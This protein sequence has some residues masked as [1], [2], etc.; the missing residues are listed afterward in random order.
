MPTSTH[1]QAS[2]DEPHLQT[3]RQSSR[4]ESSGLGSGDPRTTPRGEVWRKRSRGAVLLAS[5]LV[6]LVVLSLVGGRLWL[7]HAATSSLPKLDG[8]VALPGLSAPVLVRRDRLGTP[9]IQAAT[10]DD[11]VLAQGFVTATDRLFQ[12]DLLR[13][14]AA[15]ELAEIFGQR[16]VEHDRTERILSLDV[17][18]TRAVAALPADQLRQL[19]RYAEGVNAAMEQAHDHLPIEFRVLRYRPRPW[20]PRDTLLVSLSMYQ[21]LSTSFPTRLGREAVTAKLTPEMAADLYPTGSWRDHPAGQ[22]PVDLSAPGPEMEEIPLDESQVKL[23]RPG[24][25]NERPG[26]PNEGPERPSGPERRAPTFAS[27]A[28]LL[29]LR[30]LLSPEAVCDGC[31]KG[32]NNWVVS[33]A[34]TATGAPLLSNDMHLSLS[35]PDLWY[36]ADL[37]APTPAGEMHVAGVSLPGTPFIIVGHNAHISWGFTNL[38]AEVQDVALEHLRGGGAG[39]E[40]QTADGW[41]PVLH[42]QERIGVRG[43]RDITV[44]VRSTAHDGMETPLISD[45]YPSEGRPISLRWTVYD[46]TTPTSPFLAVN[47][48][49]NWEQFTEAFARFGGP[50]QNVVYADDGGHI[51]Y[52]AAGR[53]PIRGSV[54]SPSA[55]SPTTVDALDPAQIWVGYIP[56]GDL[57]KAF[58]P[59][60][61][62]LATANARVTPDGYPFPITLDWPDPYRNERIWKL[63]SG[64]SGLSVGDMLKIE[65]DVYSDLDL[66]IA[67]RLVYAIDHTAKPVSGR[68]REAADLLRSWNGEVAAGEAAPA[69]VVAT[70]SALWQMVLTP[71]LGD[72]ATLYTWGEKAFAQEAMVLHGP[73]RWLPP[74]YSDWNDLLAGAVEKGMADA[75]APKRLAAW[76]YGEDHPL[77][78]EHPVFSQSALLS[79]LLGVPTGE[80]ATHLSGDASTVKQIHPGGKSPGSALGPSERFTAD[81]ADLDRSTL[82]LTLGESGNPVSPWYM[83]QW[84]MWYG[85]RTADLPFSEGAVASATTHR[86]LLLPR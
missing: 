47:L 7:R 77:R 82:N 54:T 32:S 24:S 69:I 64:R 1:Q 18:A 26:S 42:R 40:F 29:S 53:I 76:R 39:A 70:R 3:R 63:L 71:K 48:A 84:P 20:T 56:F 80:V 60:R 14:H 35:A 46:P 83:D 4:A 15:G 50:S 52:H 12:M 55:L 25:P 85:N 79:R 34:H 68:L 5:A 75:H 6:L 41:R 33:G 73:E 17:A 9:H 45:L 57:P 13:R 59:P 11:L 38:G 67:H 61:G 16:L 78:I 36:S 28:D 66:T 21:D 30:R 51:G 22:P 58:D 62:L 44:D 37:Q 43:A 2:D 72:T 27:T 31:R 23:R 8:N 10:T 65:T 86:L 81:M 49:S 74:G 19:E